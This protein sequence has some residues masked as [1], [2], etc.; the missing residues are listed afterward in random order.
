MQNMNIRKK[1]T[2][3]LLFVGL[4]GGGIIVYNGRPVMAL[5]NQQQ[6][7]KT[8]IEVSL[9]KETTPPLQKSIIPQQEPQTQNTYKQPNTKDINSFIFTMDEVSIHNS[10]SNCW[11][12]INGSVYDLTSWISRHPGGPEK[13]IEICGTDGSEKFNGQHGD[14]RRPQQA[15]FLLKIGTL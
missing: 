9:K 13:I 3:T 11:S 5:R 10:P 2:I 6:R 7:Q 15:L 4:I 1:I 12:A 14:S 8:P